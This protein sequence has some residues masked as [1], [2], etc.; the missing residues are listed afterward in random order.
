MNLCTRKIFDIWQVG[1]HPLSV[2]HIHSFDLFLKLSGLPF[3]RAIHLPM[4]TALMSTPSLP[5][6]ITHDVV[7]TSREFAS[8]LEPPVTF[9]FCFKVTFK[10]RRGREQGG[11]GGGREADGGGGVQGVVQKVKGITFAF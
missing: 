2:I 3:R 1:V 6:N 5:Q 11:G 9:T 7:F 10:S 4:P 8:Y